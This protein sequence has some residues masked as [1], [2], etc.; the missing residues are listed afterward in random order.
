LPVKKSGVSR[1]LPVFGRRPARPI[2]A[3]MESDGELL[4]RLRSGEERAF[5]GLVERYHEPMLRL[6]GSFVPSRAIAEEVVQ[7]TWLAVLRGLAGFE[8]R[9]SLKTWLFAILVNQAR[10]TGTREHRSI[11]VA[12]PEPVVDPSR[13]DASGGWADPPEHWIELAQGR[14]EAG[15]LADRIRVW[16]DELPAR[17]REVVLLRDIE[18]MSSDEV[19]AVLALSDVNQRVLLHRGR[20]RLRQLFEDEF[21]GVR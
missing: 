8:G 2:L 15:K 14:M 12:D 11:P 6:A 10:K 21:R 3:V 1:P 5:I 18:G 7:D 17:Q 4:R 19:C 20:S 16:L 9:S 13:F